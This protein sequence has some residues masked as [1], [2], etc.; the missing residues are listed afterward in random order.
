MEGEI[1]ERPSYYLITNVDNIPRELDK[2][3]SKWNPGYFRLDNIGYYYDKDK[4]ELRIPRG[5]SKVNLKR[6]FSMHRNIE[7]N[8]WVKNTN[9]DINLLGQTKDYKQEYILPFIRGK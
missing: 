9:I 5:Y 2:D 6:I 4:K 7:E 1:Y 3:L 8:N